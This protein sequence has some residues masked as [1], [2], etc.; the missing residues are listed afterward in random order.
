MHHGEQSE[1]GEQRSQA[2]M[3]ASHSDDRPA[4]GFGGGS[5][6]VGFGSRARRRRRLPAR[7]AAIIVVAAV[8]V[9]LL[10]QMHGTI[11]PRSRTTNPPPAPATSTDPGQRV[12]DLG[13]ALVARVGNLLVDQRGGLVRTLD[14]PAAR[15]VPVDDDC[16]L[17]VADR[18]GVRRVDMRLRVVVDRIPADGRLVDTLGDQAF[19]LTGAAGG[20]RVQPVPID[21]GAPPLGPAF[22]IPPGW[23]PTAVLD[24]GLGVV[25]TRPDPSPDL[26]KQIGL[27]RSG[28]SAAEVLGRNHVFLGAAGNQVYALRAKCGPCP[29][30]VWTVWPFSITRSVVSPPPGWGFVGAVVVAVNGHAVAF[31]Q[32]A[33]TAVSGL[34]FSRYASERSHLVPGSLGA[35]PGTGLVVTRRSGVVFFG[36]STARRATEITGWPVAQAAPQS[37]NPAFFTGWEVPAGARLVAAASAVCAE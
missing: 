26:G 12:N 19:V 4:P 30:E 16:T 20:R 23:T 17:L 22:P 25:V 9:A 24:H 10:A 13:V 2:D 18:I 28:S 32:H 21:E 11:A 35:I 34:A 5:D 3:T 27:V 36:R 33:D 14:D 37:A 15:L 1:S 8:T 29:L 6:V 7:V 31:A